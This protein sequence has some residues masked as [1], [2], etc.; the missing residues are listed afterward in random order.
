MIDFPAPP[1]GRPRKRQNPPRHC[2]ERPFYQRWT[3]HLQLHHRPSGR[4]W[5]RSW[6]H[7]KA[8]SSYIC[9]LLSFYKTCRGQDVLSWSRAKGRRHMSMGR[10]WPVSSFCG[11]VHSLG[12]VWFFF[13]NEKKKKRSNV[14]Q[15][16]VRCVS[17]YVCTFQETVSSWGKATCSVLTTRSR[18]AW[19]GRGRRVL[20]RRQSPWTGPSLRGSC[21]RNRGSTWS[22]RWSR[23]VCEKIHFHIHLPSSLCYV[24]NREFPPPSQPGSRSW[25]TSTAKREKKPVT[26]WNSNDWWVE[27][28]YSELRHFIS[29]F[30]RGNPCLRTTRA[31]WK[32]FRSKWSLGTWN[33]LRKRRS[34]KRNVMMTFF[35]KNI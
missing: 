8:L 24:V 12:L 35:P 29:W 30:N 20:R 10:E 22:R 6:L 25:K 1:Q 3:L 16:F 2:P 21:W 18:L 7:L 27:T 17:C 23:G 32:L 19:S 14:S 5:R 34:Q 26:C 31:S 15:V 28:R 13:H 11:Q 9:I 4:R 33:L